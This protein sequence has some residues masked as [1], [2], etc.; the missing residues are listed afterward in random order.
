MDTPAAT[1][2]LSALAHQARLDIFRT[3]LRHGELPAGELASELGIPSSTL[4]FHLKDL[5]IAG[6]IT[7][8]RQGR[9][10]LYRADRDRLAELMA[11]LMAFPA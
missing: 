4:S 1:T 3:L 7:S 11:F 10:L 8:R 6:L 2:T 5:R 9:H